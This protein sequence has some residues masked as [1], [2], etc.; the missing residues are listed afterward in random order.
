MPSR[1]GGRSSN[2]L[3][4]T[5]TPANVRGGS[6]TY[7]G[8]SVLRQALQDAGHRVELVAPDGDSAG[9]LSRFFFNLRARRA[10]QRSRYDAIVGFD[11]DGLFVSAP[12]TRRVAS[13]KGVIADELRFERG[14][15]RLS[16]FL[17]SLLERRNV[18]RAD[19]VL[20]TSEYAAGRIAAEYGAAREKIRVV[21]EPIDLARWEKALEAAARIAPDEPVVLCVAHLYPRKQVQSLLRAL[22]F[23]KTP[24]K[25]RVVG[26]GP[27][28]P[29]LERLAGELGLRDRAAFLGHV[30][31]ERLAEEYRGADVFCLPSLQEGF[32][33]VFLEAMAAGLPVV[34][35]RAAAVPEVVADGECGI[36]VPP[37]DVRA[38][39]SALDRLLGDGAL[40]RRLGA[41]GRRRA[42]RYD[43]PVVAGRFLEAI[44]L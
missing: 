6:G 15:T 23:V 10:A 41:A 39:A 32:G 20:A 38:L 42:A 24:A 14:A 26:T 44:G 33:I 17:A 25:L 16:L 18:V 2:L 22:T 27:E 31:F 1:S 5:G 28:L 43:A 29:A 11:L 3:F 34:A 7:V 9:T 37:G 8:I 30:P 36:L 4:V 21:P 35:C 12:G 40:R 19:R 13:I